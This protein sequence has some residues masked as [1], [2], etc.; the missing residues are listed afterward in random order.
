ME[1]AI[2]KL[3]S[4]SLRKSILL[5]GDM[6][7]DKI[8]GETFQLNF[9]VFIDHKMACRKVEVVPILYCIDTLDAEIFLALL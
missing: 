6:M 3:P 5:D 7:K 9:I 4:D 2:R 8:A 1:N